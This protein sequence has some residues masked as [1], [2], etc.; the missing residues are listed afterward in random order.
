MSFLG[1]RR[2]CHWA[3]PLMAAAAL[4]SASCARVQSEEAPADRH[5]LVALL[6]QAAI[7]S[8][9]SFI[10]LG[11]TEGR[12]HLRAGWSGSWS[13]KRDG[14]QPVT[15]VWGIGKH[16]TVEF[17]AYRAQDLTLTFR[18]LPFR[19]AGAPTQRI[20]VLLN[21][22]AAAEVPLRFGLHEYQ[23]ALP[24][25]LVVAGR[26]RLRFEYA[27]ATRPSEVDP[28]S[29]DLRPL[30]VAW[31]YLR[32]HPPGDP[33]LSRPASIR[34]ETA[35]YLPFG[36]R[37]DY[38]L[39]LSPDAVLTFESLT[40]RDDPE[41]RVAVLVQP[42]GERER[43][44]AELSSSSRGR[45]LQIPL[46]EPRIVRVA[47]RAYSDADSLDARSGAILQRPVVTTTRAGSVGSPR[48]G[49]FPP[50]VPERTNV[51]V[52]LVD[53]L[54]ADH[55]GCYGYEKPVSPNIDAFAAEATLFE[56]ALANASYTKASV[57]SL[58]TGLLPITHGANGPL[59]A[60]PSSVQ[61][62]AEVL[63]DAD[64]E[65]VA[66]VTNGNVSEQFGYDQGFDHFLYLREDYKSREIHRLSPMVN[67][68]FY[69]WLSCQSRRLGRNKAGSVPS[70]LPSK[71][72]RGVSFGRN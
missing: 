61:T 3:A 33:P 44:L 54:R 51:L 4:V 1:S 67:Q 38:Y 29:E 60:L 71:V 65:T 5:D 35:L 48:T 8:P 37:V 68:R 27:Y 62:L 49:G 13:R 23:T 14:A 59:A 70:S 19:Y 55:L 50:A 53:T 6:P 16:S 24:A 72:T 57:A 11:S 10:D 69:S 21:G 45:S 52:Y 42:Q 26:N 34:G 31:D 39:Q 20:R 43:V 25:S 17:T 56:H 2:S 7:R 9:T 47:L 40:L 18:C 46:P 64:Y 63:R 66:V 32:F 58:F 41:G 22:S 15:F 36:S 12:T 28:A 30:A